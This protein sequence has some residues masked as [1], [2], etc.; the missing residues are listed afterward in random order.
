MKNGG[1]RTDDGQTMEDGEPGATSWGLPPSHPSSPPEHQGTGPMSPGARAGS[2][3]LGDVE[4]ALGSSCC[5]RRYLNNLPCKSAGTGS[6]HAAGA[7]SAVRAPRQGHKHGSSTKQHPARQLPALHCHDPRGMRWHPLI[8]AIAGLWP[9]RE[10]PIT[11]P[12]DK[13]GWMQAENQGSKSDK[14]SASSTISR[15][16]KDKGQDSELICHLV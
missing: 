16:I 14:L 6:D 8:A 2:R 4:P 13:C 1:W 9:R 15:I 3:H 7:S 12:G 5:C 11:W 10:H